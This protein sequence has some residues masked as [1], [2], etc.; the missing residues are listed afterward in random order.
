VF[1]FRGTIVEVQG[2]GLK[3]DTVFISLGRRH[4]VQ[5]GTDG[6]AARRWCGLTGAPGQAAF[7]VV[8]L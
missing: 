3:D 6:L 1:S 7:F 2:E 4:G 5:V 8:A